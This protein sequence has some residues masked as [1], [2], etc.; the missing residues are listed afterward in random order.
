MPRRNHNARAVLDGDQLAAVH[1]LTATLTIA[2]PS[3]RAPGAASAATGT[4]ATARCARAA[5]S[6]PPAA[7]PSRGR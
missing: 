1:D 4:A 5:S 2:T 3:T 7:A 6:W